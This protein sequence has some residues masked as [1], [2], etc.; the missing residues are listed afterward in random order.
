MWSIIKFGKH[1]GKSLP[2]VILHDPDWFFWAVDAHCFRKY[3][4]LRAEVRDLSYKARNIKIPKKI[5]RSGES[6]TYSRET[7]NS[8][9]SRSSKLRHR[10]VMTH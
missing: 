7:E 1:K 2:E 10:L 3:P 4:D 9:I 6:G 8:L 5:R